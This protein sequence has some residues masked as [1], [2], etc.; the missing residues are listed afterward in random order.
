M[1]KATYTQSL[2][3]GQNMFHSHQV[4]VYNILSSYIYQ[5]LTKKADAA[6]ILISVDQILLN[7]DVILMMPYCL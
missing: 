1:V 7:I 3:W 2:A 4:S 5:L 6:A